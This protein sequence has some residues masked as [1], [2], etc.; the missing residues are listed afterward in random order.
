MTEYYINRG[1]NHLSMYLKVETVYILCFE[2]WL[3]REVCQSI[4][5]YK[6]VPCGISVSNPEVMFLRLPLSL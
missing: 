4:T 6:A 3:V 2:G 5:P 1:L